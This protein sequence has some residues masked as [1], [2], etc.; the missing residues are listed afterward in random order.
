MV[1]KRVQKRR[2]LAV[3]NASERIAR[4]FAHSLLPLSVA[5]IP[6]IP[7]RSKGVILLNAV[8]SLMLDV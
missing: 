5:I 6:N 4:Q 7:N 1:P 3:G 2:Q 8:Q